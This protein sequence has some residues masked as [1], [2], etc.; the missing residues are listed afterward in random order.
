MPYGIAKPGFT[1]FVD[2]H[3]MDKDH[4]VFGSAEAHIEP[5]HL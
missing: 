4:G 2:R 3:A 1:V 5:L